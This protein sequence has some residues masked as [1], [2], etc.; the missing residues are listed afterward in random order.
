MSNIFPQI[1]IDKNLFEVTIPCNDIS[2][3]KSEIEFSLGYDENS[4]PS[5]FSDMIDEIIMQ[6]PEL[7]SIKAGYKLVDVNKSVDRND[8]LEIG[9][10]FFQLDRIVTGQIKKSEKAALFACSIG[11]GLELWS[12]Q[13]M[14]EGEPVL[15]FM[16]DAVASV[17]V[18]AIANSLHEHIGMKMKEMN[19]YITNR[20]S[21]GYCNWSVAEQHLL[22]SFFPQNFCGIKLT[23]SALML[24]VKSI[25]GIIGVGAEVR[26]QEYLCDRCGV[27]DCTYKSKREE[28]N[29]RT[30]RASVTNS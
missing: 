8:G 29:V 5:H 23:D 6:I 17:T 18:E 25:S 11:K 22:F 14:K 30:K 16:V 21:P 13:L 15:S 24:P 12:S 10:K 2:I 20:Y 7:C 26:Y 3:D 9:N 1:E 4:I 19:L 28:R 27:K